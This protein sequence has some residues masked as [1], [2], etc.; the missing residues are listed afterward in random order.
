MWCYENNFTSKILMSIQSPP[1]WRSLLE[2]FLN[3]HECRVYMLV[4]YLK[5]F[6]SNGEVSICVWVKNSLVGRKTLKRQHKINS[7]VVTFST[8]NINS[9]IP[10]MFRM[11]VF[12]HTKDSEVE[13]YI[14]ML[15]GTLISSDI[16]LKHNDAY[17]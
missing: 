2:R 3:G 15:I 13:F 4:K 17:A 1:R 14:L 6:T 7:V 8:Y 10:N 16:S 5:P 11:L 9:E 12:W